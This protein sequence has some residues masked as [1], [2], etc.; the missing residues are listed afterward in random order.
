MQVMRNLSPKFLAAMIAIRG[1]PGA[2]LY[3][4]DDDWVVKYALKD[5]E[6]YK[7]VGVDCI[8]LENDF[9]VP[10]I[11]PPLPAK[12]INLMLKIAKVVRKK[13]DGPIGIQM[14][15]AANNTS[16][17]IAAKADLD[18]IRVEGYIFAHVGN[19][20]IVEG[21]SGEPLR[22][23]K[24]LNV[25]HIKVFGDIKK[26]HSSHSL[27][28][29]LD[30]VDELK[31]AEFDLIDGVIVTGMMTGMKPDIKELTRVKKA[32]TVPVLI[33][34][35]MDAENIKDYLPLAD[36]FIVG[37]TFRKDGKFLE[38]IDPERLRKFVKKFKEER[39]KL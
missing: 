38:E 34:S 24:K 30:I 26:K 29:D 3:K 6:I 35:G 13:F 1:L 17:E 5:L 28:I 31:Q 32:A 14:L 2:P 37:S 16:L 21:C 23:R 22:L 27:T 18:F 25:E 33:G 20:G 10:Y 39:K 7:K 11:K 19:A 36:G 9:D 12:A 15:K 8:M 4:G